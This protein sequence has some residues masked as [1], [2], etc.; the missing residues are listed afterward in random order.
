MRRAPQAVRSDGCTSCACRPV[1]AVLSTYTVT[2]DNLKYSIAD[3][4]RTE[5]WPKSQQP[6]AP[7]LQDVSF[8]ATRHIFDPEGAICLR[9]ARKHCAARRAARGTASAGDKELLLRGPAGTARPSQS[10]HK[11]HAS[12]SEYI[13]ITRHARAAA[14]APDTHSYR[15]V[16]D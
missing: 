12:V 6:A 11:N 7:S 9:E 8:G 13:Y 14:A 4:L 5:L 15:L 3:E 16:L 1:C 10:S 2:E